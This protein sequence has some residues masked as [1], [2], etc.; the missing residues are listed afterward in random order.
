[1]NFREDEREPELPLEVEKVHSC[2]GENFPHFLL[3][4]LVSEGRLSG[5][6]GPWA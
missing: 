5:R 2:D 3:G 4:V 6:I 1:M